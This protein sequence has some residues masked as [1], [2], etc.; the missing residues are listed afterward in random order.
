MTMFNTIV[1]PNS[2]QHVWNACSQA[3]IGTSSFNNACGYHP[4]GANF[5]LADG[6]VRFI[7]STVNGATWRALGT[8]TGG[9]VISADAF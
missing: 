9:E 7:K 4:G 8:V 2:Q 3:N 6:S 5:L 1:P